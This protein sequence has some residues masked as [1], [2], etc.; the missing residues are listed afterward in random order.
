[1]PQKKGLLYL[2][3]SRIRHG[4][5]IHDEMRIEDVVRDLGGEVLHPQEHT[6]DTQIERIARSKTVV[7][8]EGSALHSVLLQAA[9]VDTL[10]ISKGLPSLTFFLIDEVVSGTSN[11]LLLPE[12]KAP[13][14]HRKSII[15]TREDAENVAACLAKLSKK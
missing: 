2:S 6:L 15:V 8:F 11:Y 1:M 9:A 12:T 10:C 5:I 14:E 13:T 4:R 3:R 7:A